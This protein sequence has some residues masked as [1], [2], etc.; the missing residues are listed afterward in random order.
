LTDGQLL[1]R[2]LDENDAEAF[3]TLVR[4]H[5]RTVWSV[6]R[7][8]LANGHDA[9]DAFQATF[10][11][12]VRKAR[13]IAKR[14]AVGSWLYGVAYRVSLKARAESMQRRRHERLATDTASCTARENE[15]CEEVGLII[16][17]EVNQ[18]P[19]KY[20]RPI[21]LC[22]FNGKTYT[23]AARLLG[24]P[25]GTTSVRLARAR[26]LLRARLTRRGLALSAGT[27]AA[28]LLEETVSAADLHLLADLTARA[29]LS[30][31]TA[32][33]DAAISS[34]V[35]ALAEGVVKTM[36]LRKLTTLAG[37]LLIIGV[38]CGSA[39]FWGRFGGTAPASAADPQGLAETLETP[40]PLAAD[41]SEQAPE[42]ADAA[43]D[44]PFV[45]PSPGGT[46]GRP[47]QTRIGL[48][49]LNRVL[50]GSKKFQALQAEQNAL[51]RQTQ[52]RLN[53]WHQEI[54]RYQALLAD[55]AV[56]ADQR[57]Q[58]E[59]DKRHLQRQVEDETQATKT[60]LN[61]LMDDALGRLYRE[62]LQV[63]QRI[64]SVRGLELVMF[65]NDAVTEA[66]FFQPANLQRKMMQPGALMPMVVAP[67]MDISDA[68]L[69]ALNA[70]VDA[71]KGPRR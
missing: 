41:V 45:F 56:T 13:S 34:H 12:L 1:E 61:K 5:G 10:L 35:L 50:K 24:W 25:A 19:D 23:E 31:S 15:A 40:T 8:V 4:R 69:E 44:R 2:F 63:A 18:L 47:A 33:A 43:L 36:M 20:R 38:T 32:P 53:A 6:C 49:H 58:A 67:G 54:Q 26:E 28:R 71:E 22:Y 48:I 60:K 66:D 59:R 11:V 9:E 3:S 57:D 37:I 29:A 42:K 68:I 70:H 16:N 39:G 62:V 55:P 27:V 46:G 17:D 64:A 52:Q 7:R 51:T 65:Y 14:E 30:L 21:I